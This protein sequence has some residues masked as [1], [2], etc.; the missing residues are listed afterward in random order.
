MGRG[1]EEEGGWLVACFIMGKLDTE[2][3]LRLS[4]GKVL[5]NTS[6]KKCMALSGGSDDRFS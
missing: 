1:R 6:T 5:S 4:L 3:D 2:S